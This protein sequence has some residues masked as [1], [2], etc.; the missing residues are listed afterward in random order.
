MSVCLCL[1]DVVSAEDDF[2]G[3][4]AQRDQKQPKA[5]SGCPLAL[6]VFFLCASCACAFL[7]DFVKCVCS[8]FLILAAVHN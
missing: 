4:R 7:F 5:V 3:Q 2:V 6:C 1:Q 8:V